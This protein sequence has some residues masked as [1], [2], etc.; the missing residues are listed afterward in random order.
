MAKNCCPF[1]QTIKGLFGYAIALFLLALLYNLKSINRF[2]KHST[3]GVQNSVKR[4]IDEA[5]ENF[6]EVCRPEFKAH[7]QL[8][9]NKRQPFM[10][11]EKEY[12][13]ILNEQVDSRTRM[14]IN[15][16]EI[17][18]TLS[19]NVQN[20]TLQEMK[21]S[22]EGVLNTYVFELKYSQ[23]QV[24]DNSTALTVAQVKEAL[25]YMLDVVN[26]VN[27]QKLRDHIKPLHS[28]Y[29]RPTSKF[30]VYDSVEKKFGFTGEEVV[31]S[32][33]MQT[34]KELR[35]MYS[36]VEKKML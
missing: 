2:T 4:N 10:L 19:K 31:F 26:S 30:F 21:K 36:D 11:Q 18:F 13:K 15:C 28:T 23:L 34:E 6:I 20:L 25:Y 35:K 32:K 3:L 1:F 14:I 16:L 17:M 8:Y 22:M 29:I 7:S 9:K 27:Y 24:P 5:I 33:H 12:S